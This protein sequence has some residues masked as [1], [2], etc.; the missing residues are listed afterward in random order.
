MGVLGQVKELIQILLSMI[1]FRDHMN[2]LNATGIA[3]AMISVGIYKRIKYA[4]KENSSTIAYCTL[5][6]VELE[7]KAFDDALD[8]SLSDVVTDGCFDFDDDIR[9]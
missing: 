5:S 9:L 6:Q 8:D 7:L 3:I 1:V 2:V 4:E